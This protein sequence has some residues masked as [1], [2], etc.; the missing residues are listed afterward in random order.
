MVKV[1]ERGLR[2]GSSQSDR[3]VRAGCDGR[4][5]R[6]A[7]RKEGL[8][9]D[10]PASQAASSEGGRGGVLKVCKRSQSS[11]SMSASKAIETMRIVCKPRSK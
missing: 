3:A 6:P 1:V 2:S 7:Q 8:A 5:R 11:H 4:N 10:R 9:R